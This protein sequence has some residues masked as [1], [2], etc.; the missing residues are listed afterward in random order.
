MCAL[1]LVM[2][3][4]TRWYWTPYWI[5]GP[6]G[7]GKRVGSSGL[8]PLASRLS[9]LSLPSPFTVSLAQAGPPA[10]DQR[11]PEHRPL[12][13]KFGASLEVCGHLPMS[14]RDL[15]LAVAGVG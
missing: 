10:A 13:A 1:G 11:Q 9:A 8:G 2:E 14:A 7:P 4:E 15:G 5:W 12:S 6:A 3:V